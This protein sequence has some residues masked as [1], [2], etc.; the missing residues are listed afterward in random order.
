MYI[1][2]RK[3]QQLV[4][5]CKCHL[6]IYFTKQLTITIQSTIQTKSTSSVSSE[7][8][9]VNQHQIYLAN[10]ISSKVHQCDNQTNAKTYSLFSMNFCLAV[11][12]LDEF[13][14]LQFFLKQ[15]NKI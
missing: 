5:F 13:V 1:P 10:Y 11:Q 8:P 6:F 9:L 7:H 4:L 3:L 2:K 15:N 12:H 14:F